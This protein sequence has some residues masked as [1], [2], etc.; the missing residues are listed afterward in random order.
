MEFSEWRG[1]TIPC[2]KMRSLCLKRFVPEQ[3]V[4]TADQNS[5]FLV[6]RGKRADLSWYYWRSAWFWEALGNQLRVICLQSS[7]SQRHR[8]WGASP[9]TVTRDLAVRTGMVK[10]EHVYSPSS[11]RA[12][13]LM[14]ILSSWGVDLTSWIRLSRRA[15]EIRMESQGSTNTLHAYLLLLCYCHLGEGRNGVGGRQKQNKI[16]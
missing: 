14:L 13:L 16:K 4:S 5:A 12:T 15:G 2:Y 8:G 7:M 10:M 6:F 9:S 11:A 3:I 1:M